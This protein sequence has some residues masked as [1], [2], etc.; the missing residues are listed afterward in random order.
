MSSLW[1]FHILVLVLAVWVTS[2]V[3]VN[4]DAL[5]TSSEVPAFAEPIP[6]T[7]ATVGR[8]AIMKCTIDNL[9]TYKVAWIKLDTQTLLSY[10]IHVI[11]RDKRLKITNSNQRQW[12][13]HIK[14]VNVSDRGYYMCQI[15]TEPMISQAGYLDVMV[16][17]SIVED[18]TST[19]TVVE[20]RAKVSLRC[21]ASGYPAPQISW[22]RENSK[23][24]NLGPVG[25]TRNIVQRVEGEYLNLTQVNRE[26]MGAYLCIAKNGIP[27]SVSKRILLQIN[28]QPKIRVANQ[29][30]YAAGGTEAILGCHLEA[31]PRPLTSWIRHDEAVLI[32]NNKYE[33]QEIE[34]SYK[35]LMQLKIK[36]ISDDDF[37]HYKCVAKNTFGDKEG[38]VRLIEIVT[39]TTTTLS[40]LAYK[41]YVPVQRVVTEMYVAQDGTTENKKEFGSPTTNS[42]R[43]ESQVLSSEK[44]LKP[45]KIESRM[46]EDKHRTT[47]EHRTK[48]TKKAT[49]ACISL[50]ISCYEIFIIFFISSIYNKSFFK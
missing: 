13:L 41:I 14:D 29:V 50:N 34:D 6:N 17:P 23:D 38:F 37:G 24:I 43:D 25:N 11:S 39:T 47:G 35:I 7:T 30:V 33:I 10:H 44:V 12:F 8:E 21:G 3:S 32:S 45:G 2:L 36:N 22:R 31:S 19:D 48:H 5:A 42:L 46:E 40:T 15:N 26:D 27:P 1:T 4:S 20:E 28:F 16:P 49:S 18:E 9:D